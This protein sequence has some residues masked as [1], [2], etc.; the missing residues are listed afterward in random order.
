MHTKIHRG[1]ILIA[2]G[3]KKAVSVR[4]LLLR[5]PRWL[6]LIC[7]SWT[8]HLRMASPQ[9]SSASTPAALGLLLEHIQASPQC[10]SQLVAQGPTKGPGPGQCVLQPN[11]CLEWGI[12]PSIGNAWFEHWSRILWELIMSHQ[13]W[14]MLSTS[15]YDGYWEL[16]LDS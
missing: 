15:E 12:R 5:R 7:S 14:W 16:G 10:A 3:S 8:S 1:D 2:D 11:V 4:K 6:V 13:M 9:W